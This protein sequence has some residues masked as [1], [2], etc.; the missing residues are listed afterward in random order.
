MQN[1]SNSP[2]PEITVGTPV[3]HPAYAKRGHVVAIEKPAAETYTIGGA[4]MQRDRLELIIVWDNDTISQVSENVADTWLRHAERYQLPRIDNAEERLETARMLE[5][6]HHARARTAFEADAASRI[7]NWAKAVIVADLVENQSDSMNDYFDSTTTRS[8]ILGFSR[9]TRDLFP[10]MRKAARN[11]AE[12]ADLADA[13]PDAENR[14]KW[15]M[16][17]GYYLKM[18]GRHSSGWRVSKRTLR[19]NGEAVKDLPTA[20]WAVP[21]AEPKVSVVRKSTHRFTIEEHMHTKM[22]IPIFVCILDERVERAEF[23]AFRERAR[24]YGGWYSRPWR[25][26]P[27]G[28]AFRDRASAER[29]NTAPSL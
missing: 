2:R 3:Y 18:G 12:T 17:S 23:D 20:E 1:D 4:G 9:H 8:V 22:G 24:E 13:P 14:E 6:E 26:T 29:F 16:G 28:F 25:G 5:A 10:E 11:F 19:Q 15:S 7:P 21:E 27:G